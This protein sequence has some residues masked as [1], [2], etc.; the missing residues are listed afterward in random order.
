MRVVNYT[1]VGLG[2]FCTA[3]NE[4]SLLVMAYGT[5]LIVRRSNYCGNFYPQNANTRTAD[6]LVED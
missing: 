1:S 4:H 3:Q 5:I 6:Q 2:C